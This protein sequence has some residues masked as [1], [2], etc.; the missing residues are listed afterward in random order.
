MGD[1][2]TRH[3]FVWNCSSS[4]LQDC[5]SARENAAQRASQ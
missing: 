5:G 2:V 3:R 4:S 1:D